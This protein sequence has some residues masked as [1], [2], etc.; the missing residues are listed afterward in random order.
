MAVVLK[1][2]HVPE[3]PERFVKPDFGV[4][5]SEFQFIGEGWGLKIYISIRLDVI[6]MFFDGNHSF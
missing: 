2:D 1:Q 5:S 4:P 3:L 6:L